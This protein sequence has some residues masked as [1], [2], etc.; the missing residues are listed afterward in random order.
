MPVKK[1]SRVFD[2]QKNNQINI[3]LAGVPDTNM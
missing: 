2:I 1:V 3:K